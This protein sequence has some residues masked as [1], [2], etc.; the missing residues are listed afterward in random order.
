MI[1]SWLEKL[2]LLVSPVKINKAHRFPVCFY[3]ELRHG[4]EDWD[5]PISIETSVLVNFC[6]TLIS[7]QPLQ[8]PINLTEKEGQFLLTKMEQRKEKV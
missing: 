8:T 6:G 5:L 1:P 3:Y 2:D 4:E 7:D